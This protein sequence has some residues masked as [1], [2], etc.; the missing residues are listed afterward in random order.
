MLVYR[1]GKTKYAVDLNGTGARLF[2]GRWNNKLKGC[3]YT[4]ENRALAV[5]EYTVNVSID[6]I[7]RAL[8]ITTIEIPIESLVILKEADLPGN[9]KQ[10]P[11]PSSTKNLGSKLLQTGDE[12]IIRVPST[13]IPEEY[14]YLINPMHPNNKKIKIIDI[15]DFVYDVRI[16]KV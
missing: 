15:K 13:I 16:K 11:A 14:N 10:S 1:V 8:S 5:L 6:D 7:P 4:S 3:V 12:L 9:W 2:G